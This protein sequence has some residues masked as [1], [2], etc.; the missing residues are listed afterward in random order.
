M[1]QLVATKV[2][3]RLVLSADTAADLMT[4]N[5]VSINETATLKEAVAFLTD[6]GL[7]SAPVVDGAGRAVG[8]L[9]HSDIVIHDRNKGKSRPTIS[10]Y[11]TNG[12]LAVPGRE[13]HS[14]WLQVERGDA[15][16]V[17]DIMTPAVLSVGTRD[18]VIR[19]VSEMLA[20]KVH[21]LFVVD[22]GVLVG[23]ISAFDVLR[24]LRSESRTPLR[25]EV[26]S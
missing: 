14:E 22:D 24:K 6:K 13:A 16:T 9:S 5:L 26:P 17:R 7:S 15:T 10:E 2:P 23:V 21:R 25:K 4:A 8:V 3:N 18:S 11:Y 12:D 20:F 1:E 19:V